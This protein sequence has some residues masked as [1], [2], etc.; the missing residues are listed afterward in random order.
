MLIKNPSAETKNYFK[1]Y[2]KFDPTSETNFRWARNRGKK[3]KE[4]DTAGT[5]NSDGYVVLSDGDYGK[6]LGH[7]VAYYLKNN[8]WPEKYEA[9]IFRKEFEKAVGSTAPSRLEGLDEMEI[10]ESRGDA[11]YEL[12]DQMDLNYLLYSNHF[13]SKEELDSVARTSYSLSG[14]KPVT[15][16]Y[17]DE[18]YYGEAVIENNLYAFTDLI[19]QDLPYDIYYHK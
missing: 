3:M 17:G 2:F 1:T 11:L 16:D 19:D 6:V 13:Y 14:L 5:I 4:G 12:S 8:K 10:W 18:L 15:N 9:D 7:N